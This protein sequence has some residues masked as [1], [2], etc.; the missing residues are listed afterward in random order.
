[1]RK[2]C[3]N[4]CRASVTTQCSKL[5]STLSAAAGWTVAVAF[6]GTVANA[7]ASGR[8]LWAATCSD[9]ADAGAAACGA[10]DANDWTTAA[11]RN[12]AG[13]MATRAIVAIAGRAAATG[14]CGAPAIGVA[15]RKSSAG[16]GRC[17]RVAT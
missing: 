5:M 11:E 14:G 15:T 1:M 6:S 7:S 8:K 12:A 13:E 9:G 4:Q 2:I 10:G 16:T 3:G 17:A